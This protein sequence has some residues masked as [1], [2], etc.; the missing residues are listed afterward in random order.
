M[1]IPRHRLTPAVLAAAVLL[2]AAP[3]A[4]ADTWPMF[5]HDGTHTGLSSETAI[6][7]ANASTLGVNWQVNTGSQARTSPVVAHSAALGKDL[8]YEGSDNG[9]V[10]AY[11]AVT[12]AR[13]WWHKVGATVNS[14][15]AYAGGRI[16]FGSSDKFLY[17]LNAD[18]GAQVCRFSTGGVISTSPTVVGNVVYFGDNGL[19]GGD[20]GGRFWAVTTGCVKKWVFTGFGVPAGSA[21]TVGSW[22]PP[23]YATDANGRNLIVFGSSSP[24][25]AVYAL[26]AGTGALVWR[27]A[28]QH[29]GLDEDVGAGPTISAPGVNGIAGGA[30]YVAG[31]DNIMYA[32]DLT[33][34]AK[35]WEYSTRL[36]DPANTWMRS[37]AALVGR[38]V[39]VGYG[40]GVLALDAVTGAKVWTTQDGGLTTGEVVSSPALAG[41]PSARVVMAG[42]MN[43]VVYAFAPA[44]G[45]LLWSYDT[46][47]LIYAS[48]VFADGA[49]YIA[50]ANGYLYSFLPGGPTS[51][52]PSTLISSPANNAAVANPGSQQ[53]TGSA[54]DETAVARVDVAVKMNNLWWDASTKTWGPAFT[55]NQATLAAPGA[56]STTWSFA[57]PVP[58]AGGPVTVQADA[59]DADGQ[60]DP[61]PS[62]IRFTES[63]LGSPP[64]T[65]IGQPV[66]NQVFAFPNGRQTF[67][68]AISGTAVDTAGTHPGVLKV[69]VAVLNVEHG[70]YYC[71]PAGCPSQP[72]VFW[73][74]QYTSFKATL[75]NSNA[76]STSWQTTFPTYDHPH[77]YRITAWATDLDHQID[78]SKAVVQRICVRDPGDA[79]P[80][81]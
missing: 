22:S 61:T 10:S 72:G 57:F 69:Q 71:G 3:A 14:T 58:S 41:P 53:I 5:H 81:V 39:Y 62:L 52:R 55:A 34:G 1:R 60:Y 25:G 27:F 63:P 32:L 23:A 26:N 67:P 38:T 74:A 65:A 76:T 36:L 66:A 19:T 17:A 13:V 20:D 43:G 33:T 2:A 70:E 75:G 6:S 77:K 29:F 47:T 40:A 56:P 49:V 46:Q 7:S 59:V 48:P 21:S 64:D 44:T 28:T 68:I 4:G 12:G 51:A 79:T 54:S 18:T 8:V 45:A 35:L 37:T 73:Q 11:D 42:D 15:P 9:I 31:K 78:T 30:V 16:W 24:E 50:S 80:C